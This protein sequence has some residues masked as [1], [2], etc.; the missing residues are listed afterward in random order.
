M[1]RGAGSKTQIM[2]DIKDVLTLSNNQEY[3]V[4]NK[5][6]RKGMTYYLLVNEEL[7]SDIKFCYEKIEEDLLIIEVEDVKLIRELMLLFTKN[8]I[9]NKKANRT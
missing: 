2:I 1:R 9:T 7:P 6:K 5:T 3:R 8:M 4:I